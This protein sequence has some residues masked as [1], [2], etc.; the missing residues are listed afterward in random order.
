M[1]LPF[2]TVLWVE[3]LVFAIVALARAAFDRQMDEPNECDMF[4][5]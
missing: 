2:D 4:A 3:V 5:S 1:S